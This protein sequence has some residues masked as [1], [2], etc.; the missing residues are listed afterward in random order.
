MCFECS[1]ISS[2]FWTVENISGLYGTEVN[3]EST[4]GFL[5]LLTVA[6]RLI[7]FGAKPNI[8]QVNLSQEIKETMNEI[9]TVDLI[10]TQKK[11]LDRW[12]SV[13]SLGLNSW[14]LC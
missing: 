8:W 14:L 5:T 1:F 7:P 10:L 9:N 3:L 6:G 4:G 2:V 11:E 13:K 12:H